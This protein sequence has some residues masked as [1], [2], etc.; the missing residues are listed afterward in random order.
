MIVNGWSVRRGRSYEL[1]KN[2]PGSA[3]VKI[4]DTNGEVDPTGGGFSFDPGTPAA[5]ALFNPVGG[6]DHTVFTGNVARLDYDLYQSEHY[7]VATLE[8]VDGLDRLARMEMTQGGGWGHVFTTEAQTGDVWFDVAAQVADRIND[9]LDQA[10]WST[11]NREVFSGNVR[12]QD[13]TYAYRTPALTAILD[14]ADAEFPGV[15]NFYIQR[16]GEATF[17]GRLA[18]FNPT[19]AQYHITTW[20]VGDLSSSADALAFSLTF[21]RDVSRIINTATATPK[22]IPDDNIEDQTYEDPTSISQYGARSESFH[23]LLTDLDYFDNSDAIDAT[24]KFAEYYVENYKDP[25]TRV[26]SITFKGIPAGHPKAAGTWALMCGVDIS[27]RIRLQTTH[28]GGGFDEFFFVEGIQI[29]KGPHEMDVEMTLDLSPAAYY[30]T[31][32]FE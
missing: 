29:R 32:P 18:R 22:G 15:A 12:L 2:A 21:D 13:V 4:I 17:H 9:V 23:D 10:D 1:D 31:N 7:A 20:S 24:F 25:R 5:I 16:T 27:D 19:D 14:A 30:E 28:M 26:N 3:V 8:L 6:G 11:G